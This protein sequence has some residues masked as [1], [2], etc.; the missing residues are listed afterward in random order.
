MNARRVLS[1]ALALGGLAVCA[2]EPSAA[3]DSSYASTQPKE[4]TT[5]CVAFPLPTTPSGPTAEGLYLRSNETADV[6]VWRVPCG[7]DRAQAQTLITFRPRTGS[8]FVCSM[9]V[10][11]NGL[12]YD[13]TALRRSPSSGDSLCG[14]LLLPVT[15][16]IPPT[17]T[18]GV[19][20]DDDAAF[21]LIYTPTSTS[22]LRLEVPAYNPALYGVQPPSFTIKPG[23]SGAWN[24]AGVAAQGWYF[25]INESG[26]IFAA[27]WFTGSQNGLSLDWY[28]AL[29][30]Y[31]GDSVTT[32]L[33]RSSGVGFAQGS[34]A[35]TA[36]FGTLTFEF[37]S[38]TSGVATWQMNDGRTGTL[39]IRKLLPPPAG[40]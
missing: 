9:T 7:A 25:D 23:M 30:T 37:E 35:T 34:T 29:G 15:A 6:I 33:F 20:F 1:S 24:T 5:G 13:L 4:F 26:K 40:C 39:P 38:C 27:A 28:S 17:S 14:D 22:G 3:R 11:Q 19:A 31:A 8:P 32:T 2:N 21:T 10:L 18:S 12:Q 16:Y 36:P